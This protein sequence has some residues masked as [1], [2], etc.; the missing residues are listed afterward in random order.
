MSQAIADV[1]G[2]VPIIKQLA[3]VPG[4]GVAGFRLYR[5]ARITAK[6]LDGNLCLVRGTH[7]NE[8]DVVLIRTAST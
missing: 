1:V 8:R 4:A 3:A 6:A 2:S 7:V 5:L